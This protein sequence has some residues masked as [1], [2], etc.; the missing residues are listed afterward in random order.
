MSYGTECNKKHSTLRVAYIYS[1]KNFGI[2]IQL[3][4]LS[5]YVNNFFY[6][7]KN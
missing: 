3:Q 5:N 4:L 2:D 6:F 7:F 1:D